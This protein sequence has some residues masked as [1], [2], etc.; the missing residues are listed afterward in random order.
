MNVGHVLLTVGLDDLTEKANRYSARCPF[1]EHEHDDISPGFSVLKDDGRWIC[2]KGCGAGSLV[3]LVAR[4]TDTTETEALQVVRRADLLFSGREIDQCLPEPGVGVDSVD[5]TYLR[6]DYNNQSTRKMH[7][8]IFDR[9]FTRETIKS[10]QFRYDE[11]LKAIVIPTYNQYAELVGVTRRETPGHK[12]PSKYIHHP[13]FETHRYLFGV[14]H[15]QSSAAARVILV[16]G[17]LDC[18]WM[19]QAG[20]TDTVGLMGLY[21]SEDQLRLLTRLGEHV[22]LA[23]DN[24][25]A[26]QEATQRLERQLQARFTVHVVQWPSAAKDAQDVS[27]DDLRTLFEDREGLWTPNLCF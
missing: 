26:G 16:E 14:D 20:V 21:L 2:F 3:D 15:F 7:R 25:A 6:A 12:L 9:G 23:L 19:H 10:W 22:W 18:I 1:K 4:L 27:V 5:L 13:D 11:N 8:Y 17:Q 24:D